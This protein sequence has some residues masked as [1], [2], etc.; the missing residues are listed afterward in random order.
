LRQSTQVI[1]TGSAQLIRLVAVPRASVH[2]LGAWDDF[3]A[4]VYEAAA[5]Q[6]KKP[7]EIPDGHTII[8]LHILQIAN[9]REKFPEAYI[10]PEEYHVESLAQ[11]SL[12]CILLLATIIAFILMKYFCADLYFP[13][14]ASLAKSQALYGC[15]PC[16]HHSHHLSPHGCNFLQHHHPA[17]HL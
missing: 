4:P 11:Q 13:L 14:C 3:L 8:P 12:R 17:P 5:G 7:I 10:L 2:I 15:T 9:I 6:A 16:N 1:L